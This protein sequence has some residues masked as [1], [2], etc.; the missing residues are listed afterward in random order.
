MIHITSKLHAIYTGEKPLGG[1]KAGVSYPVIGYRVEKK[2]NSETKEEF[3]SISW[4]VLSETGKVV[5]FFP[6]SCETH[7]C[8]H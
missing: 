7:I 3:D 8:V 5:Y 6:Q 2:T 4:L 1:I